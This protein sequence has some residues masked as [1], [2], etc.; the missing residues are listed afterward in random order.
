MEDLHKTQIGILNKL[1]FAPEL[2]YTDLKLDSTIENNTFQHHLDR[3][4][5]KGYVEKTSSE[6]YTLTKKG[7]TIATHIDTENNKVI[8]LRKISVHLYC[9]RNCNSELETLFYTRLK[10]PFYG[11]Q[12]FPAG[13]VKRGEEF[14]KAA[15]REL[16]EET[17][18]EGNPV[19]FN[20][21]HYLVKDVLS[22]E[23]LEDK[24]FLDYFIKN[25]TG[26]LKG[27]NEGKFEWIPIADLSKHITNP[28]D[29]ID[30]YKVAF[31]QI[32]NFDT[33]I[34][35]EEKIQFTSDF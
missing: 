18:L 21:T 30:I 28:F 3:M 19:L 10:H 17:N 8:K 9:I 27:N 23:L 20:I 1:L 29:S 14:K 5:K 26:K 24:L 2:R 15:K 32:Q 16:K 34:N 35:F 11:K 13:K 4:V 12:G 7:K 25:P 31:D 33:T 22:K 6:K